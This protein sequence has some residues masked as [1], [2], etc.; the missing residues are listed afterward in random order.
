MFKDKVEEMFG[1]SSNPNH[2]AKTMKMLDGM[3]IKYKKDGKNGL[4]ILGI[5]P[6]G[7]KGIIDKIHENIGMTSYRVYGK[8]I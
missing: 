6:E 5:A 8:I 3:D 7:R 4:I 2:R 1:I